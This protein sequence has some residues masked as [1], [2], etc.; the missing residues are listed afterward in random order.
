MWLEWSPKFLR[1]GEI[2]GSVLLALFVLNKV[3]ESDLVW[4][5]IDGLKSDDWLRFSMA[6]NV[7]KM[8]RI[9]WSRIVG[10]TATNPAGQS[11]R[12]CGCKFGDL[13]WRCFRKLAYS[14]P[15]DDER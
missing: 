2:R 8:R 4:Q 1:I 6:T 5:R 12:G 7:P 15:R 13:M 10:M 11:E 9:P 14:K 3:Q